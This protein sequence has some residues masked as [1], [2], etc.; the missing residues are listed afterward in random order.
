MIETLYTVPRETQGSW[1]S[2]CVE[3]KGRL[4]ACDQTGSLYRV[5][6]PAGGGEAVK[7]E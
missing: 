3:P 4:I 5:T 6:L 1:V 7:T 2:L